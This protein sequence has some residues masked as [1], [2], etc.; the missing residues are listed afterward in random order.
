LLIPSLVALYRL[1]LQDALDE[2]FED[3]DRHF[4]PADER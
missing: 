3:V 4:R 2:P 1:S